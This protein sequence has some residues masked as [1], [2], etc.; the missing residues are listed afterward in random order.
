M[1]PKV[2]HAT[3]RPAKAS[4]NQRYVPARGDIVYL[5]LDPVKGHEQ[6][7]ERPVVVL[8][9]KEYNNK[10]SQVFICP[11]TNTD[12]SRTAFEVRFGNHPRVTGVA[13][14]D[15]C[16]YVDFDPRFTRFHAKCPPKILEEIV[17]K[18]LAIM[19]VNS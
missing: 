4:T 6:G 11:I 18:H 9:L 14:V 8:S 12:R 13:L 5:D 3:A 1:K 16:R 15:Q 2:S 7:G 10:T 19:G 17:G